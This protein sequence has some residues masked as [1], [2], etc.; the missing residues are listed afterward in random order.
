[1]GVRMLWASRKLAPP[2]PPAPWRQ[3]VLIWILHLHSYPT[4]TAVCRVSSGNLRAIGDCL[5]G[6]CPGP[7]NPSVLPTRRTAHHLGEPIWGL[8]QCR[9]TWPSASAWRP[10]ISPEFAPHL[11]GGFTSTSG[12][13]PQLLSSI[14]GHYFLSPKASGPEAG[15]CSG[16]P[17]RKLIPRAPDRWDPELPAGNLGGRVGLASG[18]GH[19]ST[20][21]L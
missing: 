4:S 20:D 8:V 16:N 11:Q 12:L 15:M 19:C 6:G 17:K 18:A 1:M 2:P 21:I 7:R 13:G 10:L 14:P 3:G 9:N 5:T